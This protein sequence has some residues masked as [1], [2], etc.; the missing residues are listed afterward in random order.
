MNIYSSSSQNRCFRT[1]KRI[2]NMRKIIL[3]AL[4]LLFAPVAQSDIV[5]IHSRS[6]SQDCLYRYKLQSTYMLNSAYWNNGLPITP[7][8]INFQN[9][10]HNI[11]LT[12]ILQVSPY[13]FNLILKNKFKLTD[14]ARVIV[15]NTAEEAII[16]VKQIPGAVAY[17]A[18]DHIMGDKDIE[19][20]KILD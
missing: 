17:I 9:P 13:N 11:F 19:I 6:V 14:V 12:K 2:L 18:D 1:L 15:V 4:S 5:V 10:S 3:L 8:Y 20:V 16:K 7:I